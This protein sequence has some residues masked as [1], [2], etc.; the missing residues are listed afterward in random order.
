MDLG[1]MSFAR[2][3]RSLGIAVQGLSGELYPAFSLYNKDDKLTV[4]APKSAG[5]KAQSFD[6]RHPGGQQAL[7]GVHTAESLLQ[8]MSR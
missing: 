5:P 8:R 6:P 7:G 2:N 3:G 4:I 1:T